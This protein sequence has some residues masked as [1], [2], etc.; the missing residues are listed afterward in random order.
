MDADNTLEA[1]VEAAP[2]QI[3]WDEAGPMVA[4]EI[5]RVRTLSKK[6]VAPMDLPGANMRLQFFRSILKTCIEDTLANCDIYAFGIEMDVSTVVDE[7]GILPALLV[8]AS[9][10]WAP[11]VSSLNG[12]AGFSFRL[13]SDPSAIVWTKVLD[14]APASPL[15]FVSCVTKVIKE[16]MTGPGICDLDRVIGDYFRFVERYQIQIADPNVVAAASTTEDGAN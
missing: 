13:R 4:A 14:I 2:D 10:R 8:S 1:Q 5:Y 15:L 12:A 11:I 7:A 6:L 16:S 3:D 9:E